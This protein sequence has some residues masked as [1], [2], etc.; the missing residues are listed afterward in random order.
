MFVTHGVLPIPQPPWP[1]LVYYDAKH[2]KHTLSKIF[3]RET[4]VFF[5]YKEFYDKIRTIPQRERERETKK[6]DSNI[7]NKLVV[8]C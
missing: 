8:G 6:P 7:K 4:V 3:P 1:S 2:Y 5:V